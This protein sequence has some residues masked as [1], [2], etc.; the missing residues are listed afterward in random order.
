MIEAAEQARQFAAGRTR[1]TS[2]PMLCLAV[3]RLVKIIGEAAG[4]ISAE[5][6][7]ELKDVPWAPIIGMR[8]R[9]IHAYFD[10]DRDILWNTVELAIPELLMELQARLASH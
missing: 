9:L 6:R 1:A 2:M 3:A 8:N 10:I 5:T 4:R 7:A